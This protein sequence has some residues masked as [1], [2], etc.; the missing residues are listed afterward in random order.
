MDAAPGTLRTER[1]PIA[2]TTKSK[3]FQP[4]EKKYNIFLFCSPFSFS[5]R[6][7]YGNPFDSTPKISWKSSKERSPCW[8]NFQAVLI[9]PVVCII[10]APC[11]SRGCDLLTT[12]KLLLENRRS[13]DIQFCHLLFGKNSSVN[14]QRWST[15]NQQRL[16]NFCLKNHLKGW[17]L[18]PFETPWFGTFQNPPKTLVFTGL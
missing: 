8:E 1:I 12:D 7:P 18:P 17:F 16:Q 11:P 15:M 5:E 13:K 4:S 10:L 9:T 6:N 2:T 14:Q 3:M